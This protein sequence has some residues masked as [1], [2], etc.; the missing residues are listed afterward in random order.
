M[1]EQDIDVLHQ[2]GAKI[3]RKELQRKAGMN[4]GYVEQTLTTY[5]TQDQLK[6]L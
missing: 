3:E 1:V 5:M 6:G 4:K 2:N